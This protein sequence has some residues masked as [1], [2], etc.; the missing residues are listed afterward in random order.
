[1]G[2]QFS[3]WFKWVRNERVKSCSVACVF[4]S[5]QLRSGKPYKISKKYFQH[6]YPCSICNC[7]QSQTRFDCSQRQLCMWWSP[8][9]TTKRKI[10]LDFAP[11]P[12][13][14]IWFK[15]RQLQGILKIIKFSHIEF[16]TST[17]KYMW[18]CFSLMCASLRPNVSV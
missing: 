17:E 6:K 14:G 11:S 2:L 7:N 4:R 18:K 3:A 10:V 1:M 15:E 12:W 9:S 8:S 5:I 16:S 13:M